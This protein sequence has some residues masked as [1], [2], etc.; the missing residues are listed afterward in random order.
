MSS[1]QGIAVG[2]PADLPQ[3][4]NPF[5]GLRRFE[6]ED[7]PLFF[8]RDDQTYEVLRRLRLL[9]FV[10][11]LGPSGCGKSSLI[12]AGV[13]AALQAGYMA[14]E[15]AWR[16]ITLQ[17][18]NGPLEAWNRNLRP[19]LKEGKS[20]EDLLIDPSRALDTDSGRTVIL[21]DQFEEL[22][23][24]SART[25]RD[26]DV[27]L[28]LRALLSAG[29]GPM[30]RIHT[31]IT[32]RTEYLAQCASYPSLAEAINEGIYLVPEMG[33]D[34]MSQ[35]IVGPI[36]TIGAE[37]TAPLVDRLLNDAAGQPDALPVLQHALM[38]MW[39]KKRPWEPLGL[40]EYERQIAELGLTASPDA[41]R[42]TGISA[43]IAGHAG[44]VLARLNAE[45]Q[46]AAR[47]V[48]QALTE[49]TPDG[50]AIRRAMPAADLVAASGFPARTV[51]SV[52][53]A[54]RSEGFLN[55]WQNEDSGSSLV[56]ITHEAVARQWG[57]LRGWMLEE[58]RARRNLQRVAEAAKE[59]AEH[60]RDRAYLFGG[61]K[62][63]E[64][65]TYLRRREHALDAD[66]RAFLAASKRGEALNRVFSPGVMALA[67]VLLAVL[68]GLSWYSINRAKIA[69]RQSELA[70]R[71][72]RLAREQ[73]QQAI[74]AEQ[75]AR[76]IAES[77]QA[78]YMRLNDV[79]PKVAANPQVFFQIRDEGQRKDAQALAG[80][81]RQ[82]GFD[83]PGIQK[84]ATGPE[85]TEVR[86]FRPADEPGAKRIVKTL[87]Q[88]RVSAKAVPVQ[89]FGQP[90]RHFELWL[91]LP[92]PPVAPAAAQISPAAAAR[93]TPAAVRVLTD[94]PVARAAAPAEAQQVQEQ[95]AGCVP[96]SSPFSP[97]AGDL[98]KIE[99][100]M[101]KVCRADG[102]PLWTLQM[103]LWERAAAADQFTAIA[104]FSVKVDGDLPHA[105]ATAAGGLDAAQQRQALAAAATLRAWANDTATQAQLLT[106]IRGVVAARGEK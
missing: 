68:S 103:T 105:D 79:A 59:W 62:L 50:R 21:V 101:D 43:F 37:I 91:A 29:A 19:H 90:D 92:A 73:L 4:P 39:S 26:R 88:M 53:E 1:P 38:R 5:H 2:A 82:E 93:L 6:I 3:L 41:A 97:P 31:I 57:T 76:A 56:D 83:V 84:V 100:R 30:P 99:F 75:Q 95:S 18:G 60:R 89:A 23:Q 28:F 10:A 66:S 45:E 71:Q 22:F 58:S 27:R 85:A 77:A 25:G 61:L 80:R 63:A 104:R 65:Q 51:E 42:D 32:M 35:A 74:A 87:E 67:A 16:I 46:S 70:N 7:S 14:D 15:G 55:V 12:R 8:G 34:Q 69:T 33:R 52:I 96:L 47:T 54:F 86:Y 106:A 40:P 20:E 78:A 13:L 9:H 72:T 94:P 64:A 36:R 102:N 17:P 44:E 98:Q 48:F 11:V 81:L 24:Y 49:L